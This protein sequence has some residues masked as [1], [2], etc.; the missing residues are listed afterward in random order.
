MT[1]NRSPLRAVLFDLDGTLLDSEQVD[2]LAM[3]RL[4]NGDLGLGLDEEQISSYIGISSRDVLEQI[5]PSRVEELLDT[6]LSYQHELVGST[7]LFPGILQSL[8]SLSRAGLALA[9]VTGQSRRELNATRRHLAIDDLINVWVSADDTPF[10]K[11]HPAPV[12]L[13]LDLLGCRPGQA[14]MI[15]NTHF[16]MQAGRKAGTQV[17]AVLWGVKDPA[18]LLSYDPEYTFRHPRQLQF[19]SLPRLMQ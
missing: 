3:T 13:A 8:R 5:A 11:P 4:F 15:G 10:A 17:G 18:P 9:V 19:L 2:M 7:C 16:D 14:I 6:W 12:Q 1:R